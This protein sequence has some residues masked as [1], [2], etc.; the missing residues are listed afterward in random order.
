MTEA[1]LSVLP[2]HVMRDIR[3]ET[4][5]P[6]AEAAWFAWRSDRVGSYLDIRNGVWWNDRGTRVLSLATGTD[7]HAFGRVDWETYAIEGAADGYAD[8]VCCH[9]TRDEAEACA[10]VFLLHGRYCSEVDA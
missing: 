5:E 3:P 6:F 2:E 4:V 7:L 9:P 8:D 10:L 1:D